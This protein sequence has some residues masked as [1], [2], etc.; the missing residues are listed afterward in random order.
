MGV[1][2]A[3]GSGMPGRFHSSESHLSLDIH[4]EIGMIFLVAPRMFDLTPR[5]FVVAATG[6]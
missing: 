1:G 6:R 4:K 5:C 3:L 2:S